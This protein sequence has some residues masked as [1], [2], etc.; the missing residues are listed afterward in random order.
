MA[1]HT[2]A[3]PRRATT[4]T[5]R[6]TA[7]RRS[8]F[9]PHL[10]SSPDEWRALKRQEWLSVAHALDRFRYGAAYVPAGRQV[11]EISQLADQITEA[12]QGDWIAW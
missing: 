8:V 11:W 6:A 5:A 10:S 1:K 9:P 12:M 4:S 7:R 2:T 3:K